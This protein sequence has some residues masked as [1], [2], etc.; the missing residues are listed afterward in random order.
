MLGEGLRADDHIYPSVTKS[1]AILGRIDAARCVH[2]LVVKTGI[3][4]DVFM[5]SSTVDMYAKCREI[6]DARKMFDEMP[7]KIVASWTGIISGSVLLGE[8]KES[9]RLFK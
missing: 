1:I 4:Y 9:L 5:G 2:G 7:E 6:R 8:D 3:D